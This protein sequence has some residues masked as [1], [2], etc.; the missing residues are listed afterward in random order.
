VLS[1]SNIRWISSK[2]EERRLL[3][4]LRYLPAHVRFLLLACFYF[5]LLCIEFQLSSQSD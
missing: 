4:E 2:E 3:D 5:S 1:L